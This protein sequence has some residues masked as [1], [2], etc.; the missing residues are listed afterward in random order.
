MQAWDFVNADVLWQ[1]GLSGRDVF[2]T[3]LVLTDEQ[4][5][6]L[7]DAWSEIYCREVKRVNER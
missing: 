4:I 6:E 2:Y 1:T 7:K 3:D 5:A